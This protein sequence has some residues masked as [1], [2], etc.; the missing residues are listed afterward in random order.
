MLPRPTTYSQI[1]LNNCCILPEKAF[2]YGDTIG[3]GTLRHPFANESLLK[4]IPLIADISL[5]RVLAWG[6]NIS[7]GT[8][9]LTVNQRDTSGT[10]DRDV[11]TDE[12]LA[13]GGT[14]SFRTSKRF[15]DQRD[16]EPSIVLSQ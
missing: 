7:S 2:A 4:R 5:N 11:S 9:K 14:I 15:I 6:G 3:F 8:L 1:T 12:A 10:F 13:Y 16:H